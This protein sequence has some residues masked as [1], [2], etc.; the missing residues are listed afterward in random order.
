MYYSVVDPAFCPPDWLRPVVEAV[1]NHPTTLVALTWIPLVIEFA[2]ALSVLT[3]Q[4]TRWIMLPLGIGLHLCIAI[5][6]GLWSFS[7]V[8]FA[9][10]VLLL[11]PLGGDIQHTR[12]RFRSWR[13]RISKR[14]ID[15]VSDQV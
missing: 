9:A 11:T 13:E 6:M 12:A 5:V 4:R 7:L 3:R 8:M 14:P 10:C 1:V 2:L 15:H